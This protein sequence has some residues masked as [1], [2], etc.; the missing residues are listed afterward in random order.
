MIADQRHMVVK[1]CATRNLLTYNKSNFII[2]IRIQWK[3]VGVGRACISKSYIEQKKT[4]LAISIR[5]DCSEEVYRDENDTAKVVIHSHNFFS[6]NR[7][8]FSG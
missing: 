8:V 3:Y 7:L 6:Q 5:L 1:S 2:T 4:L